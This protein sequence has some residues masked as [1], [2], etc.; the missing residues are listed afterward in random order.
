M[1]KLRSLVAK[2]KG[3][4]CR[5][6][7]EAR[8]EEEV[9][10]HLEILVAENVARGM[11]L[12]E[13]RYAALRSF[14]G[15]TQAKER[16]REIASLPIID[17]LLQDFGYSL[18]QLKRNP[19]FTMVMVL[20]LALGIGANSTVF[21][22]LNGLFLRELPV[23][24][25]AR[26][27]ALSGTNFSW[28]HYLVYRDQAKS[29]ESL[30]THYLFP[31][32]AN[33]NSTHPPAHIYGMF[34]TANFM[35][36]LKI[37]PPL[38]RGFLPDEDQIAAPKPVVM[39]SYALWRSRF[40][41]NR[42]VLGKAIRL[43]NASYTV[44]GVMPSDIRT[45][46][47]GI[48]PDFW[49]PMA[50]LPQLDTWEAQEGHPFTNQEE[51]G[52]VIFGRLK[53]EVSRRQ[54][55]AELNLIYNQLRQ[56]EGNKEK[57]EKQVVTMENPTA[58]P[59]EIGRMVF[60]G[61]SI[62]LGGIAIMVLIITC[63]NVANLLLARGTSRSKE[64]AIRLAIGASRGRIIR[65]LMVGNLLLSVLGA[66]VGLL[67]AWVVAKAIS[68]V[69]VPLSMPILLDFAPDFRVLA[70]TTGIA[71]LTSILFGLAP[72]LRATRV[73]VNTFLKD[74]DNAYAGLGGRRV[75]NGLVMVQVAVSVVVLVAAALFLHSLRNGFSLDLGF[76]PENLLVVRVDPAAQGYSKE[77]TTLIFQELEEQVRKLPGVRDASVVAPLPLGI[78]SSGREFTVPGTQRTI[79]ADM[80]VVG[81][82]YFATMGIPIIRGRDFRDSGPSMPEAAIVSRSMAENLFPSENPIGQH[83]GWE[84]PGEKRIY[85]IIGVAG[86]TKSK[87]IGEAPRPCIYELAS[88]NK[89]DLAG[90]TGFGGVSLV[91]KTAGEPRALVRAVQQEVE[92]L[93]PGLPVYG[94]ETMEEQVGKSLVVA[95]ISAI[96]LG[97]FGLLA[98]SL[99]GIG[100]YGMMS[101]TVA[102]RTRRD[103][104]PC[105]PGGL[106][107]KNALPFR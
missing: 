30:S 64:I 76:R 14:G 89:T 103:C 57:K 37:K 24:D 56:A 17:T 63:L 22:V 75:R 28:P 84:W 29:F 47:F 87:T 101:Y 41:G 39:L 18:R 58:F 2:L 78:V 67:L 86:N 80:H 15:V 23:P 48:V 4:L 34:V 73:D 8:L 50:T 92:R 79:N 60:L 104:H 68:Q 21:S 94:V 71:I 5:K 88:Q 66:A 49:A 10:S 46:E 52:F 7:M 43:N 25:A 54:A 85:E 93:E 102:A 20:T 70:V 91:I 82:H 69:D 106:G 62:V 107:E 95:R 33:L 97:V 55:Q 3:V 61:V 12:K 96:F 72:A 59:G 32:S 19:G 44:V 42:D 45:L 65:Q 100:L 36:T 16:W 53:P 26:V 9:R 99:A 51:G 31:F 6:Q 13:A 105:R 38:G 1:E 40:G 77:R 98:L 81:P 83:L 11:S 74:G 27:V 35:T 90:F